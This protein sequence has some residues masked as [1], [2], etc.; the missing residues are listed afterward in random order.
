MTEARFPEPIDRVDRQITSA[1]ARMA[2]GEESIDEVPLARVLWS[3]S[4]VES[5]T[6]L[7]VVTRAALEDHAKTLRHE[8]GEL[9]Y[10]LDSASYEQ[11]Q[12]RLE[13]Q[14]AAR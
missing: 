1:L 10:E 5:P 13:K 8:L 2:N 12:A 6:Q 7:D 14:R 3:G 9:F 4:A 11:D